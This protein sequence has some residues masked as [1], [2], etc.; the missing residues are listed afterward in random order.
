MALVGGVTKTGMDLVDLK[1][2]STFL[3]DL[4]FTELEHLA[5]KI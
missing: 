2:R 5:E 4:Q 3:A 1:V